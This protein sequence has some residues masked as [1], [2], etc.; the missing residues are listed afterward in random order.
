MQGSQEFKVSLKSDQPGLHGTE[1]QKQKPSSV[2]F[3]I[4]PTFFLNLFYYV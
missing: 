2:Y 4:Y 1:E 3:Y